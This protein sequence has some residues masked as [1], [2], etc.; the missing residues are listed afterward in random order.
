MEGCTGLLFRCE[1]WLQ[2]VECL[3]VGIG[4]GE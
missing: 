4:R 2:V 3:G 1:R